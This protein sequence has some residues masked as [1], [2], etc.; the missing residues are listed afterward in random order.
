MRK[1]IARVKL[2]SGNGGYF[3][4]ITRIHLTHGDPEKPVYSGMN[5]SGLQAA[6]RNRRISVVSGSLGE[7]IP[8]FKLIRNNSGKVVLAPNTVKTKARPVIKKARAEKVKPAPFPVEEIKEEPVVEKVEEIHV[9]EPVSN[10]F[11]EE[12]VVQEEISAIH[13][14]AI[15]SD[16]E[17]VSIVQ[18]EVQEEAIEEVKEESNITEETK[19]SKKKKKK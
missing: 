10:P 13:G 14:E 3:D 18:E 15:S 9:E 4:P 7:F 16:T 17:V 8:P 11:A 6:V 19:K 2:T 1:E 12:E 5:V